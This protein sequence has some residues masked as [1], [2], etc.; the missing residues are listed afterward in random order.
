MK[1]E[2]DKFKRYGPVAIG[3]ARADDVGSSIQG[4]SQKFKNPVDANPQS[5]LSIFSFREFFSFFNERVK[6]LITL[7]NGGN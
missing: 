7:F 1:K 6:K 4:E 2:A 3:F 5:V